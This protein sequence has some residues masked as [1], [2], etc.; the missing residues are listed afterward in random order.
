MLSRLVCSEQTLAL[1]PTR[2]CTRGECLSAPSTTSCTSF[3]L[4]LA[5]QGS[6]M[7]GQYL[8][9]CIAVRSMHPGGGSHHPELLVL[10]LVSVSRPT[11][12][13]NRY[14]EKQEFLS[15]WNPFRLP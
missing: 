15:V 3:L 7:Q 4:V 6:I 10:N 2:P 5:R 9:G 12:L 13:K 11:E 14:A 8:Q 1:C